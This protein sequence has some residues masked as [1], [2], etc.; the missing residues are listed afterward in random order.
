MAVKVE[1]GFR[2]TS[3][4]SLGFRGRASLC[5]FLVVFADL[6]GF[7]GFWGLV[8]LSSLCNRRGSTLSFGA[9]GAFGARKLDARVC[10]SMGPR[11]D[12]KKI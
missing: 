3:F 1:E 10:Q 6:G 9:L 12:G 5:S 8:V 11:A 4:S 2:I 7:W